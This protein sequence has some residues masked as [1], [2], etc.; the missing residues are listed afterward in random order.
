LDLGGLAIRDIAWHRGTYL[1]IAGACDG[2]SHFRLYRWAGPGAKPELLSV[3][4]LNDYH[5]ESLVIY[6]QLGLQE[7]QVLSDDGTALID[8][9][10]CKD[11]KDSNRRTFRSFWVAQ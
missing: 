10:P 9:C 3:N 11:L 8:G 1:I 4:H 5:P 6:P 2:G 7:F